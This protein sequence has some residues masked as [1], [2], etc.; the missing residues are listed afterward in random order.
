MGLDGNVLVLGTLAFLRDYKGIHLCLDA[1]KLLKVKY[2]ELVYLVVGDGPESVRLRQKAKALDIERHIYFVGF[3]SDVPRVLATMDIFVLP[4]TGGEGVPQAITQAMAM[5]IPV[6][7]TAVGGIPEVVQ[8]E[9]TGLLGDVNDVPMLTKNLSRL[10]E[11][12]VL[13][14]QLSVN[15]KELIAGSYTM[16]SMLESIEGIYARLWENEKGVMDIIG[17]S[18]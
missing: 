15:A 17:A 18:I 6:V 5:G 16:E 1:V 14:N 13:R 7:S 3:R 8:H 11:D 9:I 12:P 4:S 2:P 10:I